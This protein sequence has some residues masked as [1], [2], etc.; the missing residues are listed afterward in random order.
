[1]S[2][3]KW[4]VANSAAV[5]LAAISS[6]SY[7]QTTTT[8]T[9][10]MPTMTTAPTPTGTQE[11]GGPSST[12]GAQVTTPGTSTM[13]ATTMTNS[14]WSTSSMTPD[15]KVLMNKPYDY[16]DLM[17]A[18]TKGYDDSHIAVFANIAEK[19]GVPF[20]QIVGDVDRGLTFAAIGQK[21]GLTDSQIYDAQNN[22]TEI[23]EY[24]T[25]YLGVT[26][27]YSDL[28]A[29]AVSRRDQSLMAR[30]LAPSPLPTLSPIAMSTSTETVAVTPTPVV[31]PTPPMATAET[32][33]PAKRPV[34]AHRT[35]TKTV[36]VAAP[37]R[38]RRYSRITRRHRY[39]TMRRPMHMKSYRTH[40]TMSTGAY[41]RGS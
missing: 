39:N 21:Y 26:P 6:A 11:T 30:A 25:A 28:Y 23:K 33:T 41:N 34:L 35:M 31:T 38:H 40:R 16:N 12:S 5:V 19:A 3:K 7:A 8:P 27:P 9:T 14:T 24:K 13:D 2:A 10:T 22:I 36:R 37:V 20:N 15:Y 17:A 32:L 4:I 29:Q 1:M 18:K